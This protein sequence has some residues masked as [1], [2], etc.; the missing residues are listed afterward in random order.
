MQGPT[1]RVAGTVVAALLGSLFAS[2]PSA[3]LAGV[4]GDDVGGARVACRC[5]D[6]VV[7]DTTLRSDDPVLRGR[8]PLDGLIV[9]ASVLAESL[10]LDL[11]GHA[12]VGSGF[13]AGVR[14][15]DG[16]NDGAT[17]LGGAAGERGEIVGFGTGLAAM[18]MGELARVER[19]DVKG[20]RHDG[21]FLRGSGLFVVAVGSHDNG[22]NGIRYE[23]TGGR[24][25]RVSATG[26]AKSGLVIHAPRV[27][28]EASAD[29]NGRHGI[30]VDGHD[31]DLSR[32]T[33]RN[34]QGHGALVRSARSKTEGFTASANRLSDLRH[35]GGNG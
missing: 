21:M 6:T 29:D 33:A 17:I 9:H 16:G 11:A 8:C 7:S 25:I 27:V 26:N 4:C 20:S 15:E 14:V 23:G 2:I 32:A 24:L 28:V 1:A 5:G 31:V 34:N 18:R 22:A 12:I 19:I 35:A 30:I 3:V 10:T 13:G